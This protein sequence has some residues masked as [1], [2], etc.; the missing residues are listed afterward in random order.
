MYNYKTKYYCVYNYFMC[1][2]YNYWLPN[3]NL[4]YQ[5]IHRT[6][7]AWELLKSFQNFHYNGKNT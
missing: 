2:S 1:L 7:S 6:Y 3:D 4:E 5:Q